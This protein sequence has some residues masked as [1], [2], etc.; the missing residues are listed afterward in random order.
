MTTLSGF[1]QRLATHAV[2]DIAARSARE[3]GEDDLAARQATAKAHAALREV[4][5]ELNDYD[6]ALIEAVY[7]RGITFKQAAEA[8]K[9]G[10]AA[11][12]RHQRT[13][14]QR[15]AARLR[16]RGITQAPAVIDFPGLHERPERRR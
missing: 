5:A 16:A 15:V 2:L 3:E 4:L 12:R 8:A 11:Y 9:I 14:L 7:F 1:V 10:C 13:V 6:R